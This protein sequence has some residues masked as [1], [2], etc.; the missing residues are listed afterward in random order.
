MGRLPWWLMGNIGSLLRWGEV[1]A[2]FKLSVTGSTW[3]CFSPPPRRVG[4]PERDSGALVL[5]VLPQRHLQLQPGPW[6]IS[7]QVGF[8]QGAVEAG[9][10]LG[11][12]APFRTGKDVVPLGAV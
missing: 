9:E 4:N 2:V 3:S 10:R 12:S 8:G 6:G 5:L 7:L 1:S 11:G